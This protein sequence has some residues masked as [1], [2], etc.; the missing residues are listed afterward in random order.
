MLSLPRFLL[1]VL[2]WMFPEFSLVLALAASLL[3]SA[4]II[5]YQCQAAQI[6]LT[7]EVEI[8]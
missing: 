3:F 5:S 2:S 7:G 1:L 6:V 8:E 4:G